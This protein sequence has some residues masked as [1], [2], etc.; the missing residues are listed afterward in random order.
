V[1]APDA[2]GAVSYEE[3][4]GVLRDGFEHVETVTAGAHEGVLGELVED[5]EYVADGAVVAGL[6]HGLDR[7]ESGAAA[8][9]P[10]Q[11]E[12]ALLAGI[13]QAVAPVEGGPHGALPLGQVA[14]SRHRAG[15]LQSVEEC[16]RSQQP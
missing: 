12:E 8:E 6:R 11:R 3:A 14:G 16:G 5:P 1:G 13:E 9:R 15:G 2:G 7:L 4:A 10:E